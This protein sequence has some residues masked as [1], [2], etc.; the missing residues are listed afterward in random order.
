M[1]DISEELFASYAFVFVST[2][3]MTDA[4]RDLPTATGVKVEGKSQKTDRSV[5]FPAVSFVPVGCT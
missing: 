4:G 3:A 5:Q 2:N 1:Y